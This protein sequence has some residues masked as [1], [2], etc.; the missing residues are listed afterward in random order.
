M[1]LDYIVVAIEEFKDL[2]AMTINQYIGSLQA[3]KETKKEL[4]KIKT[5]SSTK[6]ILK[7]NEEK[8]NK[9][10]RTI[11]DVVMDVAKAIE[12]EIVLIH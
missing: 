3:H 10:I 12:E 7:E 1:N 8:F 5:N 4:R 2:D 11:M 6:L 9:K